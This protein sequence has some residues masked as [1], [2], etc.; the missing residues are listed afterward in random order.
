MDQKGALTKPCGKVLPPTW[1][2]FSI[3]GALLLHQAVPGMR[4]VPAPWNLLGLPLLIGGM[5]LVLVA[6]AQF[7]KHQTSVTPGMLPTTFIRDGAYRFSRNPM[8]LGLLVVLVGL[9]FLLGTATPWFIPGLFAMVIQRCFIL[10]EEKML[11]AHWGS[12]Y[13]TYRTQVRR[14]L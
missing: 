8:Y 9:A 12:A 5:A 6:H 4:W 7:Q 1:F 13:S 10:S 2:L 3:V 11:Q 14:W